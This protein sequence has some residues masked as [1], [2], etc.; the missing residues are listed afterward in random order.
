MTDGCYHMKRIPPKKGLGM[1]EDLV[2]I[3]SLL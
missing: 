2:V 1:I 3:N